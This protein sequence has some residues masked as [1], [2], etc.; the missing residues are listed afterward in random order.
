MREGAGSSVAFALGTA[1]GLRVCSIP[2]ASERDFGILC[3]QAFD[4]EL[5]RAKEVGIGVIHAL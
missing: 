2:D 4:D 3:S 5:S 1:R